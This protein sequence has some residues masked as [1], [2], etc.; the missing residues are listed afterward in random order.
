MSYDTLYPNPTCRWYIILHLTTIFNF[1]RRLE[2]YTI[3]LVFVGTVGS[4]YSQYDG[5]SS[6]S[7]TAPLNPAPAR[8]AAATTKPEHQTLLDID[9]PEQNAN[10]FGKPFESSVSTI[11]YNRVLFAF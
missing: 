2:K 1:T 4:N 11:L 9:N 6:G 3:Y 8:G 5:T 7:E 10:S